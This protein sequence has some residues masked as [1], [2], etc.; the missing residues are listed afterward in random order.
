MILEH[1]RRTIRIATMS[2]ETPPKKFIIEPQS[3]YY[4]HPSK[5]PGS[6]LQWWSSLVRIMIS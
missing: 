2:E 1:H 5:G 3:L 6:S 4:L